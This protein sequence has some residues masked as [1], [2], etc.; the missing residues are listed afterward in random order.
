MDP[1]IATLSLVAIADFLIALVSYFQSKKS[2]TN[3]AYALFALA[4]TIW[5]GSLALFLWIPNV[6]IL[7]FL[8]R[9]ITFLGVL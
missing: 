3:R 9:L 4:V 2:Q 6:G 1:K 8:A 5:G 7:D